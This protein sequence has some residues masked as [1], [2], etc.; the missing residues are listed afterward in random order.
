M[1]S[2]QVSAKAIQVGGENLLKIFQQNDLAGLTVAETADGLASD[3][4]ITTGQA[5]EIKAL[6]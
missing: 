4:I 3:G 5:D 6:A 1:I 2:P